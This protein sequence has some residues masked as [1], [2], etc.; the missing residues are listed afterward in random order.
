MLTPEGVERFQ[1]A[2]RGV[3]PSAVVTAY[4]GAAGDMLERVKSELRR[5]GWREKG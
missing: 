2:Y 4:F 3:P 5:T 1:E